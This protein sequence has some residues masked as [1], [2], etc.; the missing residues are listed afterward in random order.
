MRLKAPAYTA[1]QEAATNE[2]ELIL[3]DESHLLSLHQ[4]NSFQGSEPDGFMVS[5]LIY[6]LTCYF[7]SQIEI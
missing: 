3:R 7:N 5:L 2:S 4:E 1:L 6:F